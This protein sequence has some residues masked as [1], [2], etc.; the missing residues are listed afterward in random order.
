MGTPGDLS[1]RSGHN[2]PYFGGK[3]KELLLESVTTLN[4]HDDPRDVRGLIQGEEEHQ[5]SHLLRSPLLPPR[6]LKPDLPEHLLFHIKDWVGN[7]RVNEI[8]ATPW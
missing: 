1:T 2:N 4:D 3:A 8:I 6:N 5:L 7:I